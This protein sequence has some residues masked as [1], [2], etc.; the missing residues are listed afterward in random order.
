MRKFPLAPLRLSILLPNGP[1]PG[2][3]VDRLCPDH[4]YRQV[5]KNERRCA[6]GELKCGCVIS[7]VNHE[8]DVG[9]EGGRQEESH[10]PPAIVDALDDKIVVLRHHDLSPILKQMRAWSDH[11]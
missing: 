4:K 1:V 5:E 8:S 2:C 11:R 7:D 10:Q 3:F 9:E 6:D